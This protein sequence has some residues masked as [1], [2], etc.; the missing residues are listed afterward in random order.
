ML[1][2][3]ND[4]RPVSMTNLDVQQAWVRPPHPSVTF[5]ITWGMVAQSQTAL[6]VAKA[7]GSTGLEGA[8]R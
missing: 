1:S 2:T 7:R 6:T 4:Y 8:P 3:S 5:P